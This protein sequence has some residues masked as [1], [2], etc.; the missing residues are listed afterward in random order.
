MTEPRDLLAVIASGKGD[1]TFFPEVR[2][3][4]GMILTD[5][6]S[7]YQR[8][9]DTRILP[10]LGGGPSDARPLLAEGWRS[11][12][13]GRVI[14]VMIGSADALLRQVAMQM[15]ARPQSVVDKAVVAADTAA[16]RV[17]PDLAAAAQ[18]DAGTAQIQAAVKAFKI[19]Q[20]AVYRPV[21]S[22]FDI[23]LGF[24]ALD[25]D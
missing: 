1:P 5:L 13:S 4:P 7:A 3:L 6:A 11:G 10:V 12:R 21:A 8:V 25:G 22:Y 18:T 17:P 16:Q 14:A 2:V 9:T 24:N 15:P 20:R 19:A 23:S